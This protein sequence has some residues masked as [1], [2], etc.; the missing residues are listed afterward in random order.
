MVAL[1]GVTGTAVAGNA[2]ASSMTQVS[3]GEEPSTVK[4]TFTATLAEGVYTFKY[5]GTYK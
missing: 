2:K 1:V 5:K 4:G 3:A